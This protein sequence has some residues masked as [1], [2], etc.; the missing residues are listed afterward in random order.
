MHAM[1]CYS[2]IKRSGI[3]IHAI[4]WMDLGDSRSSD[5]SQTQ[6]DTNIIQILY[7]STCL[8]YLEYSNLNPWRQK[9][10]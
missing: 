7:G 6:K 5:V 4:K 2:V 8:R 10:E 1:E 9:P 3:L